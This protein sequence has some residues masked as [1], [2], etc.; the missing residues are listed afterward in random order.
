MGVLTG[1]ER[2][3]DELA[4]LFT[5]AGFALNRVLPTHSMLAIAEG[6]PI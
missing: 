4:A 2:T 5:A 3:E 6:F 1:R